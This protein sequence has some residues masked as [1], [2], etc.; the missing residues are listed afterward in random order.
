MITVT[1]VFGFAQPGG[2]AENTLG[3]LSWSP[4]RD[5]ATT[6]T[7]TLIPCTLTVASSP[8]VP[9]RVDRVITCQPD[10]EDVDISVDGLTASIQFAVAG[11][12][13]LR[14]YL[15]AEFFFLVISVL[16]SVQLCP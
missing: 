4:A 16:R 13:I 2:S 6:I 9:L 7:A 12:A 10:G 3:A 11:T 14:V 5:A 15:G 8:P 1:S